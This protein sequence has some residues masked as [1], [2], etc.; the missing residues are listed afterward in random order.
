MNATKELKDLLPQPIS[1]DLLAKID[2]LTIN[3]KSQLVEALNQQ[4]NQTYIPQEINLEVVK[5][6]G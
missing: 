5:F 6:E 3:Q 4:L 2:A 1:Q